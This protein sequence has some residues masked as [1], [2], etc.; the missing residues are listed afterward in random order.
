MAVTGKQLRATL[1]AC[2]LPYERLPGGGIGVRIDCSG[3]PNAYR[4]PDGGHEL[5]VVIHRL[6]RGRRLEVVAPKAYVVEQGRNLSAVREAC[7]QAEGMTRK[8]RFK[9]HDSGVICPAAV[10][11]IGRMAHTAAIVMHPLSIVTCA[12]VRFDGVIRRAMT[13]GVVLLDDLPLPR[14]LASVNGPRGILECMA[15]AA[16]GVEALEEIATGDPRSLVLD[17]LSARLAYDRI[18]N[19][20]D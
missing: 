7:L 18:V 16:G 6:S 12:V 19:G 5:L 2:G 11:F 14:D 3:E 17:E 20:A 4:N 10:R 1:R 13:T 9:V 15:T 8:L